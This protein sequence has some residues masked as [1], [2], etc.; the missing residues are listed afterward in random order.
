[1]KRCFAAAAAYSLVL[2]ALL[3]TPGCKRTTLSQKELDAGRA[4]IETGLQ[5]WQKG[6]K[7]DALQ[8]LSPPIRFTDEDWKR[9]MRLTT[10]E[11]T[12][13]N[14]SAGDLTARCEV[15][16][17]LLDRKGN[18]ISRRVVYQVETGETL[19]IVRDPYF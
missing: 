19:A 9:G 17:S 6:E 2:A 14:G 13:A 8:K 18:K 12:Y 1:M 4:A 5:A 7:P 15:V 3:L 10:W 16:L 11:I